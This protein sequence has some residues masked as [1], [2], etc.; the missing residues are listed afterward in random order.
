MASGSGNIIVIPC[1]Q[2][3]HALG[4]SLGLMMLQRRGIAGARG[5]T[6]QRADERGEYG[7]QEGVSS[8]RRAAGLT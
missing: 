5:Y 2:P 4:Q 6:T 3:K 7:G 8:V 1:G